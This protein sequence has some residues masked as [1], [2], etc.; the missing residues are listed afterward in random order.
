MSNAKGGEGVVSF[1]WGL[2]AMYISTAV[3]VGQD[4]V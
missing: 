3:S 2:R 4:V 1:S